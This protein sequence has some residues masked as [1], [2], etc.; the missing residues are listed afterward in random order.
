MG[1]FAKFPL[2]Y[3]PIQV[4]SEKNLVS[5]DAQLSFKEMVTSVARRTIIAAYI[6]VFSTQIRSNIRREYTPEISIDL[7]LE[8]ESESGRRDGQLPGEGEHRTRTPGNVSSFSTPDD[9]TMG[10]AVH[11][12]N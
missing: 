5:G 11:R 4:A 10:S 3:H 2:T 12:I 6:Y 8:G 1:G 7:V 9:G